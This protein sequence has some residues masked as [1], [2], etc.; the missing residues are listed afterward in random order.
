MTH[1][2]P[3]PFGGPGRSRRRFL[4]TFTLG[5]ALAGLGG[6]PWAARLLA[7]CQPTTRGDGILRVQ[8]DDFPA[9]GQANG[10]V[11]LALNPFIETGP[12]GPFYP[13]LINRNAAGQFFAL[14]TRCSHLFCVVP[15][16]NAALG[17]SVCPCHGSH[18]GIDGRVL[19]GPAPQWLTPYALSQEGNVLCVEIPSLGFALQVSVVP[20][21]AS[22]RLALQFPSLAQLKYQVLL[23]QSPTDPGSPVTFA[24]TA[25]GPLTAT[26]FTG[27]GH[28]ATLYVTPPTASAGFFNLTAAVTQG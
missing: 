15:P 28:T 20:S 19:A 25:T 13:I 18:Y 16:F 14:R 11:R 23:H 6:P 8:L 21:G 24:T 26:T 1:A 27:T 2:N 7:D 22:S 17:A 12:N 9:L 4:H 10:S 3:N 5:T